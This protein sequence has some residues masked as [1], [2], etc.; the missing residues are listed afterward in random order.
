MF[1]RLHLSNTNNST[2]SMK[3]D[4][5]AVYINSFKAIRLF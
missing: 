1:K 3:Y 4:F 2:K 5:S